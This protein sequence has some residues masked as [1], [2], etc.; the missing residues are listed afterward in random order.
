MGHPCCGARAHGARDRALLDVGPQPPGR[1]SAPH[2]AHG[3]GE[4]HDE[5][6]RAASWSP[7]SRRAGIPQTPCPE[8]PRR[9][10]S[11]GLSR[12]R[13]RHRNVG[14]VRGT[15]PCHRGCLLPAGPRSLRHTRH[16]LPRGGG[17]LVARHW[18]VPPSGGVGLSIE[19]AIGLSIGR[20]IGRGQ[21]ERRRHCDE[22][23]DGRIP[24]A[25]LDRGTRHVRVVR[26]SGRRNGLGSGHVDRHAGSRAR[27]LVRRRRVG[28]PHGILGAVARGR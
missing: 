17:F 21:V 20:G 26:S 11:Q 14:G 10:G 22:P 6:H 19:L 4:A 27:D 7:I 9:T 5:R 3:S 13:R 1:T 23:A 8:H 12:R 18:A 15:A 24:R 25:R 2:T 16:R 28:D